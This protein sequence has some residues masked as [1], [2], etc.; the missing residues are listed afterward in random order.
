MTLS[1]ISDW[2]HDSLESHLRNL[3]EELGTN[4][5]RLFGAMRVVLTG[6]TEAPPLFS[7]MEILGKKV[8]L[9]RLQKGVKIL[10]TTAK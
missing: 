10:D 5:R 9:E 8:V 4:N 2:N 6:R 7:T 1:R 3:V